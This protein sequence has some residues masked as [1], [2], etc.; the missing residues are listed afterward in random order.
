MWYTRSCAVFSIQSQPMSAMRAFR[1]AEAEAHFERLIKER[2]VD[3]DLSEWPSEMVDAVR[4]HCV[5]GP[6]AVWILEQQWFDEPSFTPPH[7]DHLRFSNVEAT[8]T[9]RVKP[10]WPPVREC[11]MITSKWHE[12][13]GITVAHEDGR[14]QAVMFS[15]CEAWRRRLCTNIRLQQA[16]VS[17][18]PGDN[19]WLCE[20]WLPS[21]WSVAREP[22]NQD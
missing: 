15:V 6:A 12:F 17:E 11:R 16:S 20:E 19:S 4:G 14:L 22:E 7:I 2:R 13:K 21:T 1:S 8:T 5:Y 10:G 3:V 18:T 9:S